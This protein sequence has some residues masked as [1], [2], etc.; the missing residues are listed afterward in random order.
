MLPCPYDGINDSSSSNEQRRKLMSYK[1]RTLAPETSTHKCKEVNSGYTHYFVGT[2][3][4]LL[5]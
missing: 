4:E 2:K 3:F 5:Y 1:C